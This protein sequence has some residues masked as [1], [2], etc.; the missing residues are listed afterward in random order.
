MWRVSCA[1]NSFSG[2]AA[3]L[4]KTQPL[5][6]INMLWSL[7]YIFRMFAI[8]CWSIYKVLS[9][10]I[11][12]PPLSAVW[13]CLL[14]VCSGRGGMLMYKLKWKAC[15]L[16]LCCHLSLKYGDWWIVS[17]NAKFCLMLNRPSPKTILSYS[18]QARYLCWGSIRASLPTM[19]TTVL[20]WKSR[21]PNYLS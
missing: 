14:V 6:S 18:W 13:S 7:F 5:Y 12:Q 20:V 4:I 8:N 11:F 1:V 10:V 3:V 17:P 15:Y 21:S 19:P 16:I 2:F 9:L